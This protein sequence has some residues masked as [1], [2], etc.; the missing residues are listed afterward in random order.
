MFK[1]E[2]E[3]VNLISNKKCVLS[4]DECYLIAQGFAMLDNLKVFSL[5]GNFQDTIF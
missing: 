3:E 5:E 2:I 4:N 1:D